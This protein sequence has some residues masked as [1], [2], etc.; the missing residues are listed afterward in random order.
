MCGIL[1]GTVK[2]WD[3]LSGIQSIRHRGP[4]AV[5]LL[6][7]DDVTFA[8]TR[9]SV[10]D[11]TDAG[12]Q[13]MV[14]DDQ[15]VTLIFNGE[16]YGYANLKKELEKKYYFKSTSDTEVILY[17]YLEWQDKFIEKIDGMFAIAIYDKREKCIKLFRDRTGIK[18]LY[19]YEDNGNFGFASEL[20]AL[21]KA[22]RKEPWKIDET[23]LYDYL[24][25]CY[26][27]EPKTMY[28]QVRKLRPGHKLVYDID[29]GKILCNERYW[30]LKVN[31]AVERKRKKD[32]IEEE[33]RYL[34]K[35]SV[36]EQLM[37]DVPVGT[38]LSGGIDSSIITYEAS[39]INPQIYAYTIGFKEK[40]YDESPRAE[41]FC[42]EKDIL[43]RKKI[44][45]IQDIGGLRTKLREWFD[46]PF[47]DT[48]AYPT[49]LVSQFARKE[50]T[51]VLTGD[52][53]DELF[54]G[55]GRYLTFHNYWMNQ[56]KEKDFIKYWAKAFSI[57]RQ[58]E[59][60]METIG[61][62]LFLPQKELLE[63][64]KEKWKIKK[65]YNPYAFIKKFDIPDLPPITR[66]RY[67]DFKT[68][69]SG[70]I[71]TKVD[72]TSM[73]VSLET[74]V[75]LLSR[76]IVEF[77]FSLTQEECNHDNILKACMKDAY[78]KEIPSEILYGR[79]MG[80]SIPLN[81][82]WREKKEVNMYAGVLK[83]QWKNLV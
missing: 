28:R 74:R 48:S 20:K 1:G 12:M 35:K 73:A 32:D 5:R 4:D 9:L 16:I 79:K 50:V 34:I 59:R 40:E 65:D 22:G 3:Y 10:R 67:L 7:L 51:V 83:Q 27:P 14:S 56:T 39:K 26:I 52:G 19:Y 41:A 2:D 55:Y 70:D 53:G 66:M 23:A 69:L 80:F 42:R 54:G 8:F 37:A 15:N 17:A 76:E 82:M 21:E 62:G 71:L 63:E 78:D 64:Y 38:F 58:R 68:Y 57:K 29:S 30:R 18:P 75:P 36:R 25:Y 49:F 24:F 81:Y 11:L 77:A 13:P 46:E 72:R 33:L 60:D 6:E 43:L 47:A 44:V 31:T 45:S 61:A